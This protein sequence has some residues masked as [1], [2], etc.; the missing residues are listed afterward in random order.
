MIFA[1]VLAWL[2]GAFSAFI[3][4][5][6]AIATGLLTWLGIFVAGSFVVLIEA[7][8]GWVMSFLSW[9]FGWVRDILAG[10]ALNVAQ[11]LPEMSETASPVVDLSTLAG[12]VAWGNRYLPL[13]E[14][15]GLLAAYASAYVALG[16]YKLVKLLRGGG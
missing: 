3:P 11:R 9:L 13:S 8:T 4:A 1:P 6:V 15:F 14:A 2:G 16:T 12:F 5:L 7:Q 10:V